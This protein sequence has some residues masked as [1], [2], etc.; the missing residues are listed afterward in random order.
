MATGG[1]IRRPR[2]PTRQQFYYPDSN[3]LITRFLT[4]HGIVEVQD[5]LVLLRPRDDGHRQRLVRRVTGV[6]GEVGMRVEIAPR[7]DYARETP[8]VTRTRGGAR[9]TGSGITLDLSSTVGLDVHDDHADCAFGLPRA[10]PRCS[11]WRSA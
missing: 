7:P 9:F 8:E 10:A 1:C 2:S 6:R 3:I 4:E 5:F 11:C